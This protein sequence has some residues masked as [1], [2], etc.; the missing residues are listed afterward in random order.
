MTS[1]VAVGALAAAAAAACYETSYALQALEARRVPSRRALHVSLLV[2]LARRPLW[3]GAIALAVLGWPLQLLALAHAPLTLVQPIIALGV[4]LLLILARF[5]LHERIGHRELACSAGMVVGVIGIV[6]AAPARTTAHSGPLAL[7][8]VLGVLSAFVV[9]PFVV[10]VVS[11]RA[12]PAVWLVL[13]AGT[14]DAWAAFGAKLVVDELA[15]GRWLAAAGF[16]AASAAALGAGLLSETAALQQYPVSR[17]G[18]AV[19]AMQV[20]IPVLLAPLIGG[21]RWGQT[22]LDGGVLGFSLL[23]L[24]VS[25]A[26]LAASG[27]ISSLGE[28]E[29]RRGGQT[30]EAQIGSAPPLESAPER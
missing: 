27:P 8:L 5:L 9:A 16:G 1:E 24:T 12:I 15:R 13:A 18:P 28:H 2:R 19:M 11:S 17:V 21:E 25:G 3:L 6:W 4:V 7:G 22:P 20:A 26:V 23:L 29:R 30:G 14:G 10:G